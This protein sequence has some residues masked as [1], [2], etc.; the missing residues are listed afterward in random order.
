MKTAKPADI[1]NVMPR[2]GGQIVTV[3]HAQTP[4]AGEGTC[5]RHHRRLTLRHDAGD[6]TWTIY[7]GGV[8]V[9]RGTGRTWPMPDA[10]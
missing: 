1:W 7:R 3:Y 4:G 9:A 6:D 10:I 8:S 5:R 2:D